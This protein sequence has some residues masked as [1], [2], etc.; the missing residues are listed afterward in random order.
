MKAS[1]LEFKRFWAGIQAQENVFPGN[2]YPITIVVAFCGKMQ[3][4]LWLARCSRG[5]FFSFLETSVGYSVSKKSKCNTNCDWPD[6]SEEY[7]FLSLNF[8]AGLIWRLACLKLGYFLS[9]L[10][11]YPKF[12]GS[13][14][15]WGSCWQGTT[16]TPDLAGKYWVLAGY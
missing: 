2:I 7:I 4:Q 15:A 8:S 11:G 10:V 5:I 3:R 6:V 14:L 12:N 9:G 1:D 13:G 16:G